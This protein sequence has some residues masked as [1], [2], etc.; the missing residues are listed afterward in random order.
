M[1]IIKC[2]MCKLDGGTCNYKCTEVEN[3]EELYREGVTEN[4]V[5]PDRFCTAHRCSHNP[6]GLKCELGRCV[7]GKVVGEPKEE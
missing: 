1:K 2:H 7:F 6:T 4:D 5:I 3:V